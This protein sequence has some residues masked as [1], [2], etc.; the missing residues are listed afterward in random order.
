MAPQ[1]KSGNIQ[2]GEDN[3]KTNKTTYLNNDTCF[4]AEQHSMCQGLSWHHQHM[5]GH[6]S[7]RG[8]SFVQA[9]GAVTVSG[10][11]CEAS[12]QTCV[13]LFVDQLFYVL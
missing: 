10:A 3:E 2:W 6:P 4:V 11:V 13:T 7:R 1:D 12:M 8:M 9:V 5:L